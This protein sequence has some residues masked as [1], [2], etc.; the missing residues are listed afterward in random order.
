MSGPVRTGTDVFG[1]PHSGRAWSAGS[2]RL[3]SRAR[4]GC[5]CVQKVSRL[6]IGKLDL[7]GDDISDDIRQCGLRAVKTAHVFPLLVSLAG[8]QDF[9]HNEFAAG[10]CFSG[11]D[12]RMNWRTSL[13]HAA[14]NATGRPCSHCFGPPCTTSRALCLLLR[15]K[16][17]SQEAKQSV[18]PVWQKARARSG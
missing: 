9:R 4:R 14:I 15:A 3:P 8:G 18:W 10:V 13:A 16:K 5:T 1:C 12:G 17:L 6:K 11:H 2:S 7:P